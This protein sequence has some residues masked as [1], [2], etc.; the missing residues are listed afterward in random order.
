MLTKVV[1]R[2]FQP[3]QN[4][5]VEFHPQITIICGDSDEGKSSIVRALNWVFLN[6]PNGVR[7]INRKMD[8]CRVTVYFSDGSTLAKRRGRKGGAKYKLNGKVFAAFG[9]IVPEE[10]QHFLKLNEINVQTQLQQLFWIL[11]TPGQLAS[12]LNDIVDLSSID[13][14]LT[15][16]QKK[17]KVTKGEL[18]LTNSKISDLEVKIEEYTWVEGFHADLL[19]VG[20]ARERVRE[21]QEKRILM[22]HLVGMGFAIRRGLVRLQKFV[23]EGSEL[24]GGIT[25]LREHVQKRK[26]LETLLERARGYSRRINSLRR[27]NKLKREVNSIST[28]TEKMGENQQNLTRL[29]FLISKGTNLQEE[30]ATDYNTIQQTKAK[31][32]S[33]GVCPLCGLKK[34][35]NTGQSE[36]SAPICTSPMSR[37]GA[38]KRR[39]TTGMP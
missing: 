21:Q 36:S 31:L 2:G 6:K 26:N 28:K 39:G 12:K 19:K 29:R 16:I 11:E 4:L 15:V 20:K 13:K 25:E 8:S 3:H 9:N 37:R 7:I 34:E 23:T 18:D 33:S 1:I 38:D 14:A 30:I 35:H 17:V 27:L 32:F 24:V 5:T 22:A 10:I